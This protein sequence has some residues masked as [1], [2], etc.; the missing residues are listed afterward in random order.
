MTAPPRASVTGPRL[1]VLGENGN[2]SLVCALLFTT[3]LPLYFS[4][5]LN[6]GS[7]DY[8]ADINLGFL[9]SR[10]FQM[11]NQSVHDLFDVCFLCGMVRSLVPM[12]MWRAYTSTRMYTHM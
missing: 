8:P 6:N 2:M 4:L 12:Q 7:E 11:S 9:A 10:T 5:P 1:Q 3:Y